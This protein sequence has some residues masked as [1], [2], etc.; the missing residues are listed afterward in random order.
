MSMTMERPTTTWEAH[1][2][3]GIA[4]DLTPPQVAQARQVRVH[5]RLIALALVLVVAICAG[6]TLISLDSKS[7]AESDNTAERA[8]TSELQAQ[9]AKYAVLTTMQRAIDQIGVQVASLMANDIDYVNLVARIR[10]SLPPELTLTTATVVLSP[11]VAGAGVTP[12][13]GPQIIGSISLA[14]TAGRI[15]DVTPF[16]AALNQLRGV[17]DVVPQSTTKTESGVQFAAT[18]SITDD[19]LTHRFD[20]ITDGAAAPSQEATP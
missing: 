1:P 16:I 20:V 5:K 10:A 11:T 2:G 14:G 6:V 15:K 18:A 4:V 7:S 19:L 12:T 13:A 9:T 17:V 3:W 8:R